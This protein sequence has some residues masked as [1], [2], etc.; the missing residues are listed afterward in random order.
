M[1]IPFL[2]KWGYNRVTGSS[3]TRKMLDDMET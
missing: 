2:K 1:K 3:I